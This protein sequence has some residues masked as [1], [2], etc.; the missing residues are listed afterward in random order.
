MPEPGGGAEFLDAEAFEGSGTRSFAAGEVKFQFFED[1]IFG[2][3][4]DL[5]DES[6]AA[7]D[8]S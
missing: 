6:G 2:S 3:Q 5:F 8:A 7:F 4:V 1:T